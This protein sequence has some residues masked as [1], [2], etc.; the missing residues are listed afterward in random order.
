MGFICLF[1]S[2]IMAAKT[3]EEAGYKDFIILEASSKVG[4]RLHK[5]NIGGHTIELGAN[6]VNSGG[7]KSSPSLQIAKKIKLK[8]FYSDYANLTSNIYKQEYTT[9]PPQP[10]CF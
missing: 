9:L 4:G 7:P 10:F 6:W 8:T 1:F 2:G 3:L 5:G